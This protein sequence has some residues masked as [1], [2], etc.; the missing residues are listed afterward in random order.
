[1]SRIA[2]RLAIALIKLYQVTVSRLLPRTCRFHPSCS[3]YTIEA[4]QTYGLW[5]GLLI[6]VKRVLRC[7]PFSPGGEDPVPLPNYSENIVNRNQ[8]VTRVD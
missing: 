5:R 4:L 2:T 6:G 8:P 1:M 3:Q 7:H